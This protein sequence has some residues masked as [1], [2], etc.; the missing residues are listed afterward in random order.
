ML[1]WPRRINEANYVTWIH[2][3]ILFGKPPYARMHFLKRK[4]VLGQHQS[5]VAHAYCE[6]NSSAVCNLVG[7]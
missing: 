7:Q 3:L 5:V 4:I 2:I 1:S 6:K